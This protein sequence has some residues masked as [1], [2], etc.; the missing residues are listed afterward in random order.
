MHDAVRDGLDC[1]LLAS[2]ARVSFG[3][4]FPFP[5]S[6]S[7]SLSGILAEVLAR[8]LQLNLAYLGEEVDGCTCQG[9]QASL[10]NET[11]RIASQQ[12]HT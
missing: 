3:C 5:R 6:L 11:C 1:C 8:R 9:T 2:L 10:L 4:P 7:P 12:K